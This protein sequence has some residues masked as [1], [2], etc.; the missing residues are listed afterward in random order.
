ML[1][2]HNCGAH[3]LIKLNIWGFHAVIGKFLDLDK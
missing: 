1:T 3:L 2:N